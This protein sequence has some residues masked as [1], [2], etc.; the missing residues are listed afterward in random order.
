MSDLSPLEEHYPRLME[1]IMAFWGSPTCY[2]QLQ[3]FLMDS[4]G[5]RNGFPAAI[6][7]DL[8]MLLVITARAKSP[9]DIWQDALD[10]E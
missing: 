6:Y 8:S 10:E 4:R 3:S 5:N 1:E 2:A 7:S 9:Y